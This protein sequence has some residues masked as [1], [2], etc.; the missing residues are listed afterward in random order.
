MKNIGYRKYSYY[1]N[2]F[3]RCTILSAY[4]GGLL[5]ADGSLEKLPSGSFIMSLKLNKQDRSLVDGLKHFIKFDG[6]IKLVP[7]S[8]PQYSDSMRLRVTVSDRTSSHLKKYYSIV[9]N[10]TDILKPPSLFNDNYIKAFIIGYVD[11]DGSIFK[12]ARGTIV[13]SMLGTY[14][15]LK[16]IKSF[17][18]ENFPCEYPSNITKKYKYT[19]EYRIEGKRAEVI[20]DA[21]NKMKLPKLNR[22]WSINNG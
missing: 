20:I 14:P 10:K 3:Q 13:F 5:A 11:G 18:D 8:R 22:K 6:P 17:I 15:L 19:G 21:L 1:E 2:A 7:R 4:Y 16:W 12:T 9:P